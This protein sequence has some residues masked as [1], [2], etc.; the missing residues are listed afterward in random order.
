MNWYQTIG[1]ILGILGAI[2]VTSQKNTTRFAAFLCWI[3]SNI[4]LILA[5]AQLQ[6]WPLIAMTGVYFATS[7]YGA[8]NNRPR[9]T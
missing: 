5:Y 6:A 8:W 2:L 7:A 4:L 1:A 9:S 3:I